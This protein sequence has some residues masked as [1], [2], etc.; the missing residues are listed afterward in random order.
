MKGAATLYTREFFDTARAH[1]N[2]GGVMTLY[3]AAVR[4]RPETVRS[5]MATFFE[6]FP[7]GLVFGNVFEGHAIDSVLVGPVAPPAIWLD[8]IESMLRMPAFAAVDGSLVQAGLWGAT[9]LF[10]NYAGRARELRDWLKDAQVNHDRDLRLQYLAG[11]G[12][13]SHIGGDIYAEMLSYRTY[14]DDLF[15][16]SDGTVDR[17]KAAM[18]GARE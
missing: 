16:A 3:R 1:L 13:N 5:E 2:P 17:L 7:E 10:G 8:E 18:D 6:T 14:P 9:D 12:L 4:E 11:L 15:V